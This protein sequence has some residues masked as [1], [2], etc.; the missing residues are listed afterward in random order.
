MTAIYD[1]IRDPGH[2]FLIAEIGSNHNGDFDTALR[3]MDV[4]RRAGADAVKFQSFLADHL[5]TRDNRDYG[6]L[7]RIEMPQSW[8]PRLKIAADERGLVFFSTATNSVTLG[9]LAEVGAELYK[10]ASPN[11]THLPLIREVAALGRPVIVS[12]GM[13]GMAEIDEAVTT[14]TG[15]GNR[16]LALLHCT[17]EYPAQPEHLNL[18]AIPT[19]ASTFPYPIGFS[20]HSLDGGTAVAAV[21]LGAK[22]IEKHLTLDRTQPGPD[23][24][25][26]LESD[27]FVRLGES[28]RIVERALG[29]GHK[30][31]TSSERDKA[32]AYWRSLHAARDLPAGHVIKQEDV[33]VVRP[34]D[35][36]HPRHLDD[37]LGMALDRPLRVGAPLR[38]DCFK[39]T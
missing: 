23:H 31:P 25:Y 30:V 36:L 14:F 6:L 24:H 7:K 11:L 17:S 2:C 32:A 3:L 28:I 39:Q 18:R 22:V 4:A 19:L 27:D 15:A 9:W 13:A 29:D 16:E 34:N 26:A 20:D 1:A 33:A 37:V 21:A 38:W 10:L 8:Y 5:V 35:G 12:T